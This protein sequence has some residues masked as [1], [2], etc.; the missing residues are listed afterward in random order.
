MWVG[1]R[2]PVARIVA[3]TE[4]DAFRQ[5]LCLYACLMQ[6]RNSKGVTD[7][8][9]ITSRVFRPLFGR[10]T[11]DPVFWSAHHLQHPPPRVMACELVKASSCVRKSPNNCGYCLER[12]QIEN[13]GRASKREEIRTREKCPGF[14][15]SQKILFGQRSEVHVGVGHEQHVAL[16]GRFECDPCCFLMRAPQHVAKS[17]VANAK[18]FLCVVEAA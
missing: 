15:R 7:V 13:V 6:S 12:P 10:Q 2:F 16:I 18:P 17:E 3:K 9:A 14:R 5:R 1:L 8:K 4:D 11:G